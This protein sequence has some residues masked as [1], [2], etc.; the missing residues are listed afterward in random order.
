MVVRYGLLLLGVFA[1]S[2]SVLF[3]KASATPPLVLAAVRLTLAGLLLAPLLRRE[4]Q[5][6]P[7]FASRHQRR[8]WLPAVLLAVHFASWAYGARMAVAAQATLI[9]NLVPVAMPFLLAAIAHERITRREILGTLVA[10]AGLVILTARDA[11]AVDANVWGNVVCFAAMLLFAAYLALGRR[12]RDYPSIWLYVIP[13][14]QR[15]ALV[16]WMLA[17]PQLT[18]W[19]WASLRE[20]A[21]LFGLTLAPTVVGHSLLNA[22]MRHLRGQVVSLA[23]VSQFVFAGLMAAV[24]YGE[25]PSPT[26]F[27]ASALAVGGI[28]LVVLAPQRR[29]EAQTSA[30]P[31]PSRPVEP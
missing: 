19:P 9:V 4:T 16:A 18:Q 23:N 28:A 25:V 8:A 10:F 12:N 11:W 1:C 13:L 31:L 21:L 27:V 24:I 14:Y 29:A 5:R 26:F 30:S 7:E 6:Y 2:T 20:W 15:A 22:S 3:I 17:I